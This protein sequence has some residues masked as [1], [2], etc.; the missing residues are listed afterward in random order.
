MQKA[1]DWVKPLQLL[2]PEGDWRVYKPQVSPGGWSFEYFNTWYPDVGDT[3]CVVMYLIKHDPAFIGSLSIYRAAEWI[4]R[5][6]NPDGG[7]AAF[8]YNN[9]KMVL[10]KIPFSD[11][12]VLCDPSTADVTGRSVE[13]FGLLLSSPHRNIVDGGLLERLIVSAM[14]GIAYLKLQQESFSAW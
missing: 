3:A 8:D 1:I 5:V 4:L 12:N 13:C 10:N 6:Q 7:W 2:S 14:R 9:D 11:M